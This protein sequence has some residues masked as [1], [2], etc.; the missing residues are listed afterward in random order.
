MRD[1]RKVVVGRR[2]KNVTQGPPLVGIT[3][4]S[5]PAKGHSHMLYI[6]HILHDDM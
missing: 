1:Q 5:W 4:A 6:H 3:S 2:G